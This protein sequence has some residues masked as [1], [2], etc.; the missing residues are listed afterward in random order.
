M[1]LESKIIWSRRGIILIALVGFFASAY[2]F[3]TYTTGADLKCGI[4][5]G[6]DTVRVSKWANFYGVP[7]PFFGLIFYLFVLS[8]GIFRAYAPEY[9]PW[10]ARIMMIILA[11]AGFAESVILTCIQRFIIQQF[12]SWCLVSAI[13][14]SLIFIFIFFDRAYAYSKSQSI[15]E[16]KI[17]TII[18]FAFAFGGSITFAWLIRPMPT[19]IISPVFNQGR[20][21]KLDL[22]SSSSQDEIN[23][24]S[25]LQIDDVF[26]K[27]ETVK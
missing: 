14:A 9:K 4:L 26:P 6:C 5:H 7:T 12:C 3:Y 23:P 25:S 1:S 10:L 11:F 19:Q 8:L 24:T 2:L 17:I 16:L 22:P 13:S 27:P 15:K 20:L 18:L 21:Q